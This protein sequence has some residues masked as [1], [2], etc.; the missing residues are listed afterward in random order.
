MNKPDWPSPTDLRCVG[1]PADG[2]W[3]AVPPAGYASRE[4]RGGA[5]WEW[6]AKGIPFGALPWPPST[7]QKFYTIYSDLI[8]SPFPRSALP[9]ES[10]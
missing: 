8:F 2:K 4:I 7:S 3:F 10:V 6:G 5:V 9:G 1:G